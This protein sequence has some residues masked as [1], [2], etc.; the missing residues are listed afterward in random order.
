RGSTEPSALT[1]AKAS[2]AACPARG[3]RLGSARR[4]PRFPCRGDGPVACAAVRAH[5]PG[6]MA[7]LTAAPVSGAL[8]AAA[9]GTATVDDAV[10]A[11]AE[12]PRVAAMALRERDTTRPTGSTT[13]TATSALGDPAAPP[14]PSAPEAEP[15]APPGVASGIP[16][17]GGLAPPVNIYAETTAGK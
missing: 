11:G 14:P 6:R 15:A 2:G 7:A 10:G 5:R 16:P 3:A 17:V 13:T 4:R 9:R 8:L 1:A 12:R